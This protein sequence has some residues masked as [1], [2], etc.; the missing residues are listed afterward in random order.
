MTDQK[1][2]PYEVDKVYLKDT[3][4]GRV[5]MYER[6][7]AK[8]SFMQSIVP[9]PSPKK[10]EAKQPE[11]TKTGTD[12]DKGTPNTQTNTSDTGGQ[13]QTDKK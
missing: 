6:G 11:V 7:L 5:H 12:K 4:N 10:E 9:N 2:S 13:V 8:L 3:R 1:K